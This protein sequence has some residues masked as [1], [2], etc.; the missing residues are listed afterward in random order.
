M[1]QAQAPQAQA[2][3]AADAYVRITP[4]ESSSPAGKLA[5]AE[6]HFTAGPLAGMKLIGFSIWE[7]RD[8]SGRNVTMPARQYSVNGERRS[9]ALLRPIADMSA[10][11]AVRDLILASYAKWEAENLPAPVEQ[12][13]TEDAYI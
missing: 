2:P 5:D 6:L 7:R 3:Q 4:N 8:K 9:F 1:T 13:H 11:A 12:T 10:N